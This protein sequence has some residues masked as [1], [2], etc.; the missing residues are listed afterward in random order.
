M[1]HVVIWD[2]ESGNVPPVLLHNLTE[3]KTHIGYSP[4]G[5]LYVSIRAPCFF[6]FIWRKKEG[7]YI[8]GGKR[9]GDIY[10]YI[11]I[12]VYVSFG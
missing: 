7:R 12:Y 5:S 1:N 2:Y 8:S 6:L 3:K 4:E 9:R 10:I 11:Y